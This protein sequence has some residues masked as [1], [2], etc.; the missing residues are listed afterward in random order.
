MTRLLNLILALSLTSR[1]V[2]AYN[3]QTCC[4]LAKNDSQFIGLVPVNQTC[5]QQYSSSLAPA[6]P[7]YVS[8]AFCS[9][10]CSGIELSR[11]SN[12]NQWAASIVQFI[13]PSVIFSMTIPRRKKIEFDYLFEF[14]WPRKLTRCKGVNDAVQLLVSLV[15][16]AVILVP[17]TIDSIMW[18]VSIMVGAGNM[19]VGGLYEA[20]LDYRIVRFVRDMGETVGEEEVRVKRELLVTIT[21]GNLMLEKGK[22]LEAITRSI[23]IPGKDEPKEGKEKARSRLLNL[24]GA[25]TSFGNAVGSPVLFYLGAFVYTI[26]DLRTDPSSEDSAISLGFG[27]EWM[28]I[29]H[30]AIVSGCLLASNNPSTSAGIVGSGHE[31]LDCRP[32][33][34]KRAGTLKSHRSGEDPKTASH[35][36]RKRFYHL[37]FGWSNAYET[38][39]QPVSL[40]GRG[41]NKMQWVEETQA[42]KSPDGKF[43]DLMT[44]TPLGW[45]FK[46]LLPALTFI[47][48]PPASGAVVAYV[49][50]PIGMG[51]RSLSC[52]VYACCQ[53]IVTIL[54]TIRCAVDDGSYGRVLK[55][56]FTGWRFVAL[57]SLFWFGSFMAA[58]GGMTMQT[59]GVYRNCVC[60]AVSSSW[61]NIKHINP[62]IN[63]A[64]DTQAARDS[65]VYWI[66]MGSVATM[67]MAWTTYVGWWYQKL[68]RRRFTDAVKEMFEP[69]PIEGVELRRMDGGAGDT[70]EIEFVGEGERDKGRDSMT[71]PLLRMDSARSWAT[72]TNEAIDPARLSP[73]LDADGWGSVRGVQRLRADSQVPLLRVSLDK[74]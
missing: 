3:T 63:L 19:I 57:S 62:M 71:V 43:K 68:I 25:Q 28:V 52:T 60:Y 55:H 13:L 50:P 2:S 16:F 44:I 45:V 10:R 27:I 23:V 4:D 6:E 54:A 39:F 12:P 66:W 24:L 14:E 56:L 61:W 58:I 49:T 41:S 11:A 36:E 9:S 31:A 32:P 33:I 17:V 34:L 30:V 35:R 64:T 5:G 38:E 20:H 72:S 22:P 29:V 37:I 67:F 7:L 42:Y 26:L 73:R 70:V 48:L 21:S 69:E 8:Y 53:V 47:V 51:C 40:W 46:I 59:I 65:S 18:I 74:S 1:V 15:C